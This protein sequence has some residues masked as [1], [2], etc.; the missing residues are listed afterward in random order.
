MSSSTDILV[1][2]GMD[3]G[4]SYSRVAVATSESTNQARIISNTL[5]H[6]ET[7]SITTLEQHDSQNAQYVH[8]D[9]A[10]RILEKEKKPTPSIREMI[11]NDSVAACE[12]F[13][14]HVVS[15]ASDATASS[16]HQ[17]RLVLAVPMD[18]SPKYVEK[19]MQMTQAG[20]KQQISEKKHRKHHFVVGMISEPAA[21][22]IAHGVTEA[23]SSLYQRI[24]VVDMG[25]SGLK[26]S[27]LYTNGRTCC[28]LSLQSYTVIQEISGPALIALLAKHVASQF[29]RK[30]KLPC[31][32]VWEMKK[33]RF[34]LQHAS[35]VALQ[36]LQQN[37]TV[38]I[39][40]DGL[41]EGLDCHVQ[42]SKPR[43]D[44]LT[45][46][47]LRKVQAAL[48]E[49]QD[50][51][52]VLLAGS[53]SSFLESTV[54]QTFPNAYRGKSSSVAPQEAVALGCAL[55]AAACLQH[56]TVKLTT[57]THDGVVTSP[58]EIGIGTAEDDIDILIDKGTPLPAHVVHTIGKCPS[59]TA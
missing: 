53:G 15:L 43:W 37:S 18:A 49:Y 30:H 27:R 57:P 46:P 10:L 39:T 33:A 28:I 31:G 22:C 24:L 32:E 54:S 36:S 20:M 44:M 41:Y 1:A 4:S 35:Q 40:I 52:A 8:G 38:T 6:F 34:K 25:A 58:V 7:R 56:V 19:L 51:H 45:A 50:V 9:A 59:D 23:S 3:I 5:G 48:Q 29:E 55:H 11:Q 12:A 47:L 26:L 17:L 2:V 42:V 13:L 21:V 16:L 14:G